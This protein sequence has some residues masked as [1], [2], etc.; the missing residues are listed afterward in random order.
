MIDRKFRILC[1]FVLALAVGQSAHI[2]RRD[3][4]FHD[5]DEDN[6]VSWNGD[7][8]DGEM[9]EE[10][11]EDF[12]PYSEPDD[13]YP[14]VDSE[15]GDKDGNFP[16]FFDDD[17]NEGDDDEVPDDQRDEDDDQRDEDDDQRDEDDDQRDWDDDKSDEDGDTSRLPVPFGGGFGS[18]FDNPFLNLRQV[19]E[20]FRELEKAL[21][22]TFRQ[23]LEEAK[24]LNG[25]YANT[26]E[27]EVVIG[28]KK[29][30]VQ[31]SII[32][33]GDNNS[34]IYVETLSSKAKMDG[35]INGMEV[36]S[37]TKKNVTSSH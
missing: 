8:G 16:G 6:E 14:D 13:D 10:D 1:L 7:E 19:R 21:E 25:T 32:K 4:T 12:R 26:T 27:E 29:Y 23:T 15:V 28:G 36:K 33:G 30:L 22:R 3:A 5:P 2:A 34:A 20:Y 35:S 37:E 31:K 18:F 24:L 11:S 9:T 17:E